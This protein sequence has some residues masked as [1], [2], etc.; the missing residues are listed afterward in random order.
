MFC[1]CFYSHHRECMCT[2]GYF[3]RYSMYQKEKRVVRRFQLR[4][5]DLVVL[6]HKA[7]LAKFLKGRQVQ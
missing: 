2:E 4:I 1:L 6:C 3:L 5:L 7:L